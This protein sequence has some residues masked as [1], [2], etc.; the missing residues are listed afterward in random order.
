MPTLREMQTAMSNSL[1]RGDSA[2][3]SVMLAP[4]VKADRLD[5][6]RNTF[7]L[8]LIKALRICF[9]AT[10][11][12]VGDEFFEGAARFFIESH[13]PRAAWLDLYGADLPDFLRNFGPAESIPYL[14]DVAELEWAVS[15]ALHARDVPPLDLIRI[16]ALE[17]REQARV[18]FVAS[19][20][21]RLLQLRYPADAIWRAVL[22]SDDKGLGGIDLMSGPRYVLVARG[23]SGIEIESMEQFAWRFLLALCGGRPI[24]ALLEE[25]DG[26]DVATA[27]AGHIAAAR[28]TDFVI[29]PDAADETVTGQA[30]D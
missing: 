28:F 2:A 3:M 4:H 25:F 12:L 27:L 30:H 6:Y 5:I 23:A 29:S 9:P 15:E 24:E 26:F 19:P 20:S 10:Q 16:A 18:G 8:T 11:K 14:S 1:I 7:L 17:P 13:P 22:G 21:I